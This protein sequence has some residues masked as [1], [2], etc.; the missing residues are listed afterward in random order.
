MSNPILSVENVRLLFKTRQYSDWSLRDVFVSMLRPPWARRLRERRYVEV[1]RD[2]S[3]QLFPGDR[4]ALLGPNGAGKTS[5]CRC[6]AGF[7]PPTSG[8]I[9]AVGSVRALLDSQIG[10][11]PELTG[12]ENA[13]LLTN[14]MAPAGARISELVNEALEFSELGEFLDVPFRQYSKGMQVRLG[15]S[16]SAM[17]PA[18]LLIL[19]EVFDGADMF[20]QKKI[21]A[22]MMRLINDSSAV[23]FVSHSFEQVRQVCNRVLI[24]E[25]GRLSFDGGVEEGLTRYAGGVSPKSVRRFEASPDA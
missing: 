8:R 17:L 4:V 7:Y 23:I 10:I 1:C 14:I 22:R 25:N 18:D 3:F 13:W 24:L 19:D 9:R 2:V 15:L 20:F 11:Q 16:V 5:L 12:R 6:I 21:A